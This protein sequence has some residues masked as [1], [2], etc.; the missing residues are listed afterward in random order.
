MQIFLD[1]VYVATTNLEL[2]NWRK[3]KFFEVL[4]NW[5]LSTLMDPMY[6]LRA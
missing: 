5:L 3:P 6:I 4:K 2:F 1:G